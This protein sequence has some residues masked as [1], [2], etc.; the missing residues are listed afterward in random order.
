MRTCGSL[1]SETSC[2]TCTQPQI[3]ADRTARCGRAHEVGPARAH[4]PGGEEPLLGREQQQPEAA[5]GQRLV[6][7]HLDQDRE[8]LVTS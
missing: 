7:H 1:N 6:A 4:L 8:H 3:S 5:V 2:P